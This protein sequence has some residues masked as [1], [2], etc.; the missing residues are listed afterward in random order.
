MSKK[1]ELD[2]QIAPDGAVTINVLGVKG[3]TCLDLTRDLEESLGA[4]L[5][6]ETKTSFYEQEEAEAVRIRGEN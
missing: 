1:Q 4:V 5:D 6:R 2:I 3:K